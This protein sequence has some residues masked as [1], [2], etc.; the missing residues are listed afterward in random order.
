MTDHRDDDPN[1]RHLRPVGQGGGQQLAPYDPFTQPPDDDDTIDLREYWRILVKRKWVVISVLAIITVAT[2]LSTTLMIPVYRSAATIQITPPNSRILDYA[3]FS[4]EGQGYLAQQQFYTTQYEIL[5]S[6]SLA[7]AVVRA[8]NVEN[9]PE[10]TGEIRQRSLIGELRSLPGAI[11][12]ALGSQPT[13]RI[14]GL[15]AEQRRE[16]E[17]KR[18]AGT[19]MGRLSIEPVR[20]S[21]LVNV[22]VQAFDPQFAA[23]MANAVVDEYT[24]ASMQRRMDAGAQAR[25]FLEGELADMR[26]ELERADQALLDFA[27]ANQVADLEQR[28]AMANTTLEDL[29][30]RLSTVETELVQLESYRT[31][32]QRGQAADINQVS[33]S[34]AIRELR[35]QRAALATEYASLSQRFQDDYP[36]LVELRNRMDTISEQ[37]ADERALAVREILARY[38]SRTAEAESLRDAIERREQAILALNQQGVQYNILRR[39]FETNRELYDGLLQRMKEIGVAAGVQENNIAIIDGALPAGAPFS[40]N[41]SRNLALAIVLGLMAGV[42]L[43]LVLEFFDSTVHRTEDLEALTGRPVLGLVPMVKTRDQRKDHADIALPERA[44]GHYSARFP[45][46]S[47]SEAF[48]S[49]RTSLMFSTPEGMP[50]TLLITSPG[51]GD[52]KTTTAINL[53]TVMA[54]NGARVLLIDADLRKPRLHR[55]FGKPQSPGLTN[56]IAGS[57]GEAADEASIFKTDVEGL[58]IM[59]SGNSAPNPAELLSSERMG[60]IIGMSTRAFDHVIIDTAPILGLADSMVLSRQVDGLVLVASAGKTNKD[61]IK[62]SMRRL[63]QV[64]APVLGVVLNA[65]DLESP[66]YA[67]YSAY[68]YNYE[69]DEDDSKDTKALGK[70]A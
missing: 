57:Q 11:K 8:E 6:R 39:E 28:I 9:H 51:P 67:Y 25:D 69:S 62:S 56:R 54:Q 19:L 27:Q 53:A 13:A 61:N 1:G 4:G 48:R 24:R 34:E 23:R 46:S 14:E 47:V 63:A 31:M 7:E 44:V 58:F 50:K 17:V 38:N 41:L 20:N 70:T 32:I 10:L 22:S 45:K 65:V 37:I 15:S 33:D 64:R 5:R 18:A 52:G 60:K 43:A 55:D 40:P 30:A 35:A 21:N 16:R 2:L 66:D 49:L 36:T 3:D 29:N 68:Y 42:G 26:I 59:P 12:R